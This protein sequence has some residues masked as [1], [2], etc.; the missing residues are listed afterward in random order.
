MTDTPPESA[1]DIRKCAADLGR[2]EAGGTELVKQKAE[3]QR[4]G[5]SRRQIVEKGAEV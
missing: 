5:S 3:G 2:R 4:C 1:G